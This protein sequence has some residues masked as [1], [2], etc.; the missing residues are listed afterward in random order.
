MVRDLS[1][2]RAFAE[3]FA[4]RLSRRQLIK[5][6][7]VLRT[8]AGLSQQ[9][10]AEELECT[11]SKV[12]KL[13]SSDDADIRLGDLLAYTGAVGCEMRIFLVP[14]RQKIVDEVKMHTFVIKRLLDKMV[15]LAGSEGAMTE[16]VAGFLEEAAFNLTHLVRQAAAALP[17]LPDE[18]ALPL[19]VEAPPVE[20]EEHPGL[21]GAGAGADDGSET[22]A[23]R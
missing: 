6:L 10:L 3:E 20:E 4:K 11:Q 8:R 19:Q 13:E 1:E 2:D 7:T 14:E 22:A 5:A 16:A 12:S 18:P 23:R 17:G 21:R 9:D 15:R